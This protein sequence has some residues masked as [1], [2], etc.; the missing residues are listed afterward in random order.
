MIMCQLSKKEHMKAAILKGFSRTHWK[1]GEKVADNAKHKATTV[2]W[3][4]DWV[5]WD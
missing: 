5:E 3:T 4:A 1:I 2:N